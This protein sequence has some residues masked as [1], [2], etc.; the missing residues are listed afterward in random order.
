MAQSAPTKRL[1]S[2]M[3][4][5]TIEVAHHDRES[6][7]LRELDYEFRNFLSVDSKQSLGRPT[8]IADIN[9]L[10]CRSPKCVVGQVT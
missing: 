4:Q 6:L 10:H 1:I 2:R 3:L 5:E 7:R 8:V 9:A